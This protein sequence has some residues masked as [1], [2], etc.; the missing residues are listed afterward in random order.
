MCIVWHLSK[1]RLPG[2]QSTELSSNGTLRM[3]VAWAMLVCT[4]DGYISK[5]C[6]LGTINLVSFGV[7]VLIEMRV[8]LNKV[9]RTR[10]PSQRKL[11]EIKQS[12]H[13]RKS[14]MP[15]QLRAKVYR[16]T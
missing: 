16:P 9:Q 12:Q 6:E 5:L 14:H 3:D 13:G 15:K 10:P 7:N 11:L 4:C 1:W 2:C 8:P